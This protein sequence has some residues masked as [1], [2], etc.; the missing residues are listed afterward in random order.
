MLNIIHFKL[1]LSMVKTLAT[2][3]LDPAQTIHKQ[4]LPESHDLWTEM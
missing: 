3:T 2:P 4:Q 1:W